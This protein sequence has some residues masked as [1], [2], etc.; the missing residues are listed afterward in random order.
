MTSPYKILGRQHLPPNTP[1]RHPITP[2]V[3][4]HSEPAMMVMTDLSLTQAFTTP[5]STPID[6]ALQKM[7]YCGIRMLLIT[8]PDEAVIGLITARDIMGNQPVAFASQEGIPRAKVCVGD[9]MMGRDN[10]QT[11]NMREVE[12]STI[13]D[14]VVT[15]SESGRQ[16]ALVI[17]QE[18]D[19]KVMVRGIFSTTHI[20]Y[21]LGV[22]IQPLGAV[23]SFAELE[24]VLQES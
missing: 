16:H 5:A 13:G 6:E 24:A 15:L 12:R 2:E 8:D 11:L 20:G 18:P 10:I 21:K 1:I 9:I 19:G 4:H 23:Q 14:I 7:I 17:E 3:V 22:E